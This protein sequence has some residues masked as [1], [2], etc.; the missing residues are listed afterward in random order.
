[1]NA[2][3]RSQVGTKGRRTRK[4]KAGMSRKTKGMPVCDR[5]IKVLQDRRKKMCRPEE[6]GIQDSA[7]GR[8]PKAMGIS[9]WEKKQSKQTQ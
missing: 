4:I 5:A 3:L 8:R 9:D 6:I 2:G 7:F 1:M